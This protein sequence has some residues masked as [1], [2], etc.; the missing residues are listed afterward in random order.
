MGGSVPTPDQDQVDEI[1]KAAGLTYQDDEPL[2]S[3]E[4]LLK[5]DRNRW[6][7][8]PASALEETQDLLDE[9]EEIRER[10]RQLLTDDE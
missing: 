6:E 8:N 4:K 10:E 7:L 2:Q 9:D 1:G 5:R 3:G